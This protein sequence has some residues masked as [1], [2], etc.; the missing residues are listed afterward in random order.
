MGVNLHDAVLEQGK[1]K[2]PR[3]L[4][5]LVGQLL[6]FAFGRGSGGGHQA[7]DL[8]LHP[9]LE[10]DG[11]QLGA[12][13]RGDNAT[14]SNPHHHGAAVLST[15]P[16]VLLPLVV[17]YGAT[18]QAQHHHE[19]LGASGQRA[20]HNRK[21]DVPGRSVTVAE[22]E[23]RVTRPAKRTSRSTASTFLFEKW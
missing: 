20:R 11:V 8:A 21:A 14:T 5:H 16:R 18:F 4:V 10:E 1:A 17:D 3:E 7:L 13:A 6:A 15:Q 2:A 22:T 12:Q 9:D 23:E 19:M